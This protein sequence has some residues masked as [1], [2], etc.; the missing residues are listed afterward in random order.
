MDIDLTFENSVTP[1]VSTSNVSIFNF[2][3]CA[4]ADPKILDGPL[5]L[6]FSNKSFTVP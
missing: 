6:A 5:T 2:L 3:P 4:G 1:V